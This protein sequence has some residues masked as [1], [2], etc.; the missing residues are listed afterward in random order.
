MLPFASKSENV[1]GCI[2]VSQAF[3]AVEPGNYQQNITSS[4]YIHIELGRCA[5]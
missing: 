2:N 5:M 3:Y 1:Q 4:P